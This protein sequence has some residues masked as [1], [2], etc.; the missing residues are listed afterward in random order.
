MAAGDP[1]PTTVTGS[2]GLAHQWAP[3]LLEPQWAAISGPHGCLNGGSAH[4][5]SVLDKPLRA[6][7]PSANEPQRTPHFQKLPF[8]LL[9][10]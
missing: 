2:F 5:T 7:D 10:N 4:L 3:E 1:S 8:I 6:S 9:R